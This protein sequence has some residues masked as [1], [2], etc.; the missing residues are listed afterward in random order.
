MTTSS[1]V[2]PAAREARSE[3]REHLLRL[4]RDTACDEDA[5]LVERDLAGGVDV[6]AAPDDG[7]VRRLRAGEPVG[8]EGVSGHAVSFA[9]GSALRLPV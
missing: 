3:V 4:F 2:Q 9:R 1:S 5:V 8:E 6:L 7:G